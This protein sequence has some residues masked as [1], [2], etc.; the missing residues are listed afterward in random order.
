MNN[1]RY[2][3]FD[4]Q[5]EIVVPSNGY[6]FGLDE[7]RG[8]VGGNIEIVRLGDGLLMVVNAEG[9]LLALPFNFS[10][11]CWFQYYCGASDF[12]CGNVLICPSECIV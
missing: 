7:L 1:A 9:K 5:M 4:G 8:F 3:T 6:T 10:A 12:I 2:I 11:T